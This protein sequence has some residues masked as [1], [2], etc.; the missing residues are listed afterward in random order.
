MKLD[1]A[2]QQHTCHTAGETLLSGFLPVRLTHPAA[3]LALCSS[4]RDGDGVPLV[5]GH[6]HGLAL[7]PSHVFWI[8]ACQPTDKQRE[9]ISA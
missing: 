1:V 3:Q 2:W 6:D 8:C 5:L 4:S 7:H 9:K